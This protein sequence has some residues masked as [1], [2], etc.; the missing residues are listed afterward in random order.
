MTLPGLGFVVG[1]LC[2][3]LFSSNLTIIADRPTRTLRLEYQYLIFRTFRKLSFDDTDS[4][5]VQTHQASLLTSF[6]NHAT[7]KTPSKRARAAVSD[8]AAEIPTAPSIEVNEPGPNTVE[9]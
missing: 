4:I 7:H 5:H 2:L 1:G 3:V 9:K 8:Q 6:I